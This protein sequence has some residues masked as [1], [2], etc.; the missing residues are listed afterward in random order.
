MNDNEPA[1]LD[2]YEQ[3]LDINERLESLRAEGRPQP[4]TY[5]GAVAEK[6]RILYLIGKRKRSETF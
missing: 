4:S 6:Q 2:L 1:E 3:L 5:W